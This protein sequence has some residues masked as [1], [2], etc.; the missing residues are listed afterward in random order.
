MPASLAAA[1]LCSALRDARHG[2]I[3]YF[4]LDEGSGIRK[5][6]R[7]DREM[8][9]EAPVLHQRERRLLARFGSR[10]NSKFN[11]RIIWKA[12]KWSVSCRRFRDSFARPGCKLA[13]SISTN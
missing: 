13:L 4:P 10:R 3:R 9:Y 7:S 2:T 6:Q 1:A 12:A 11:K 8:R 5:F